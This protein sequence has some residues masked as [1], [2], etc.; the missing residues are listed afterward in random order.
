MRS[1]PTPPASVAPAARS[2][3][4]TSRVAFVV[5]MLAMGAH[6]MLETA[7]DALFLSN[8][9]ANRLPI[10]Y[11]A[12][13]ILVVLISSAHERWFARQ[14]RRA[15]LV[16]LLLVGIAGDAVLW[17]MAAKPEPWLLGVLYVWTGTLATLLLL[18]F[19]LLA[20]EHF[21]LQRAKRSYARIAA[22]GVVGAALGAGLARAALAILPTRHLILG[23]GILLGFAALTLL[24]SRGYSS[25]RAS[26]S[27]GEQKRDAPR[28]ASGQALDGY[29]GRIIGLAAAL[30][31]AATFADFQFKS[32]LQRSVEAS[33]LAPFLATFGVAVNLLALSFQLL[34][35][36]FLLRRY[37]VGRSL[38]VLPGALMLSG[39]GSLLLPGVG[40]AA[41]LKGSDG[42]LRHGLH[43][44]ATE[45]LFLPLSLGERSRIKTWTAAI[46][47]RAA[48]ALA[49]IALLA[50]IPL[51]NTRFTAQ[52]GCIVLSG[53]ALWLSVSLQREYV[54][55]LRERIRAGTPW[56][57]LEAPEP[58]RYALATLVQALESNDTRETLAALDMLSQIGRGDLIPLR[59]LRD[60][61]PRVV[62]RAV[63]AL[64]LDQ[65][66]PVREAISRLVEHAAPEVRAASLRHARATRLQTRIITPH[67]TDPDAD[68]RAA[69]R[70]L[71]L[72]RRAGR[73]S[74]RAFRTLER[75]SR[76]GSVPI[77]LAIAAR[78]TE[79]SPSATLATNLSQEG[80]A[81][82]V[83]LAQGI[84]LG[85]RV[86]HQDVLIQLLGDRKARSV[87][88]RALLQLGPSAQARLAD[89]LRAPDLDPQIRLHLPRSLSRFPDATV[90]DLLLNQLLRETND[91]V[92]YKLLR[93]LGGA[94]NRHPQH[95]LDR[96]K[97]E[98]CIERELAS[99]GRYHSARA[100]LKRRFG[101]SADV[102]SA[103]LLETL[104]AERAER[105]LVRVFRALHVWEPSQDFEAVY[106]GL[107][108]RDPKLRAAS[109][110]VALNLLPDAWSAPIV[111]HVGE[112]PATE[113]DAAPDVVLAEL[114]RDPGVVGV[115]AREFHARLR[116]P[117]GGDGAAPSPP[118]SDEEL[119]HV[120]E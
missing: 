80:R 109:V 108:H 32:E 94:R 7:R 77:K 53:L 47:R 70:V 116:A 113:S 12:M 8:L 90:L 85:P 39:L 120:A 99:L 79:I 115:F 81:I 92:S 93:A 68:V 56:Q 54:A 14:P 62:L 52:A 107:T 103:R 6:A 37:G 118:T 112:K 58:D 4:G 3:R 84:A 101:S 18:Q 22:G 26:I 66:P 2:P 57:P 44:A 34:V 25:A 10:A 55:R 38:R 45:I 20:S 30:T 89:A 73:G 17:L 21:D 13:G 16:G 71:T 86:E 110:E 36:P 42:S 67:L 76:A 88:R 63:Q 82:R 106:D 111:D 1:T 40:G 97:V 43:Q 31:I 29:A 72:V 98:A 50:L 74:T 28:A 75:L 100:A 24:Y 35:A 41:I 102:A 15:M 64:R 105:A 27:P 78:I 33:E 69:A 96:E 91:P 5:L 59:V 19:W 9:S 23:S 51:G 61:R 11:L 114:R 48:Q 49:S 104:L 95:P 87:A 65:R 46:G 117:S 60:E 119:A 83:A